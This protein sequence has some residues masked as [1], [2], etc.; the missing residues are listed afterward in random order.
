MKPFIVLVSVFLISTLIIKF[1]TQKYNSVLAAR[2]AMCCMLFFTAMG[3]FA[4]TQGMAMMIPS[5]IPLKTTIVYL[6][7]VLEMLL[8]LA[9]LI[10]SVRVYAAWFLILFFIAILPANIYAAIKNINYQKANF[11]GNGM[12]Y[13][14]FRVPL[15]LLFIVWVCLSCLFT[16]KTV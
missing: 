9:L 6:T 4:Y 16:A 7:G 3:H 14:W 15:Q 12:A 2:I 13:L 8:G 11:S 1:I 5:I 10:T